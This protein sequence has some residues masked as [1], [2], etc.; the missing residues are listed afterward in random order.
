MGADGFIVDPEQS[1][2]V[3]IRCHQCGRV[4][5]DG[6]PPIE[7]HRECVRGGKL[8]VDVNIDNYEVR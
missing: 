4:V 5:R 1:Y 3:E 7:R 6:D 8:A 2:Y